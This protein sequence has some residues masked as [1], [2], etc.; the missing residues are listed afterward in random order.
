VWECGPQPRRIPFHNVV[1]L[2][3]ALH[4]RTLQTLENPTHIVNPT[5]DPQLRR[6]VMGDG[7]GEGMGVIWEVQVA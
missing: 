3:N 5:V 2:N 6:G 4:S 1:A 7:A